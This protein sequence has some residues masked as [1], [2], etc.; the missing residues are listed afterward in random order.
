METPPSSKPSA[1]WAT[2]L[3]DRYRFNPFYRTTTHVILLQVALALVSIV[4]FV[5]AIEYSQEQTVSAISGQIAMALSEGATTTPASLADSIEAVE[6]RAYLYAFLGVLLLNALFGFLIARF[7]LWPTRNSLQF[8][9][10]FIGN[11][12]HEIRT[13]LAIIK[14]NTEVALFDP[15]LPRT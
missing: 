3:I 1:A 13:P 11:I 7:A 14:T 15:K 12:A 2:D 8:Q 5:W 6:S 4:L 9:K 10:R